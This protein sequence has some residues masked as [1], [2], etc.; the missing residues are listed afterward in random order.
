MFILFYFILF[1][2]GVGSGDSWVHGKIPKIHAFV[3]PM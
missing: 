1:W 3:V 2:G